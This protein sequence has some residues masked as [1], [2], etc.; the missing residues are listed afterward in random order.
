[1]VPDLPVHPCVKPTIFP[2]S[3]NRRRRQDLADLVPKIATQTDF[4]DEVCQK[5]SPVTLLA[6]DNI[7]RNDSDNSNAD[8]SSVPDQHTC[9]AIEHQTS[10][11]TS[12][13]ERKSGAVLEGGPRVVFS[14]Q[15]TVI[16]E[17]ANADDEAR[18]H[19]YT[20]HSPSRLKSRGQDKGTQQPRNPP[21]RGGDDG[22]GG[23][24]G[25]GGGAG[26]LAQLSEE[27]RSRRSTGCSLCEEPL[28]EP[29]VLC[30]RRFCKKCLQSHIDISELDS[31]V[32]CVVCRRQ[33]D[34][35]DNTQPRTTWAE[36]FP[37]DP[38]VHSLQEVTRQLG[39]KHDCHVCRTSKSTHT[40]ATIYCFDCDTYFCE[41][42]NVMHLQLRGLTSHCTALMSS[43]QPRDVMSR[44]R[45]FCHRHEDRPI[46][47][48]CRSCDHLLL[49][50]ECANQGHKKCTVL[51]IQQVAADKR[52]QVEGVKEDLDAAIRQVEEEDEVLRN[53]GWRNE[54]RACQRKEDIQA[55][56]GRIEKAV[57][58][59]R[60]RL[61][62]E[63]EEDSLQ[64]GRGT[65][66]R[67]SQLH[68]LKDALKDNG[69][70]AQ[71]L[72]HCGSDRDVVQAADG[73]VTQCTTLCQA[74]DQSTSMARVDSFSVNTFLTL[75]AALG[76][77]VTDRLVAFKTRQASVWCPRP[78]FGAPG[79]CVVP[80]VSLRT[81]EDQ[82]AASI[83]DVLLLEGNRLLVTDNANKALKALIPAH[84]ESPPRALTL[85]LKTRPWGL[86]LTQ[87]NVVAVS[88]HQCLYIV[89]VTDQTLILQTT[90][91]TRKDYWALTSLSPTSVAGACK[92]PPSVDIVD[93]TGRRLRS[94]EG[95]TDG[96]TL[97]TQPSGLAS[98]HGNILVT[99]RQH[100]KLVCLDQAG[101]VKF[102]Y[103][104][105]TTAS[106]SSTSS[107]S[108]DQHYI[109]G[110]CTDRHD[111]ILLVDG[112]NVL[113]LSQHGKLLC[114]VLTGLPD[115]RAITVG[116]DNVMA[117][118]MDGRGVTFFTL[119]ELK[120]PF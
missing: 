79:Q 21:T 26:G 49:C 17:K 78:V 84:Q 107:S 9:G 55:A 12:R 86:T 51:P 3:I 54:N 22:G 76:E 36:Q 80:Q 47:R 32:E 38:F 61:L 62:A 37:T 104:S 96:V 81:S 10:G 60:T 44:R 94:I 114:Q 68:V 82:E 45:V 35:P 57:A 41:D 117:L 27:E 103:K 91:R 50:R 23:G 89:T 59:R 28:T 66:T 113:L 15:H 42:C 70:L 92:F 111:R 87:P 109:R 118:S 46:E 63:I 97:F 7:G 93:I 6:G 64:D 115:P 120:A 108:E 1:M 98:L 31:K 39:L 100:R 75:L 95:D 102:V 101:E 73:M 8:L 56:F 67:L 119:C 112:P 58:E 83:K 53:R 11:R 77:D 13:L 33:V 74:Q 34:V 4:K 19:L 48:V 18:R 40:D 29:K 65:R 71:D 43:L 16:D 14:R 30:C 85:T 106:S 72:L 25:G 110:L 88:G 2:L 24:G 20:A 69:C 116:E 52:R 5:V 90:V 105:T 99:D